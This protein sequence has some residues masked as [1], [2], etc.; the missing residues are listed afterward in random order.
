MSSP[1]NCLMVKNT[2]Q[3]STSLTSQGLPG[4]NVSTI[5][6][7]LILLQVWEQFLLNG[8]VAKPRH[9]MH[10]LKIEERGREWKTSLLNILSSP[11]RTS[12][13][14]L[15][16][17]PLVLS[18]MA[19]RRNYIFKCYI[20]FYQSSFTVNGNHLCLSYGCDAI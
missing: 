16:P 11:L 13:H 5:S 18:K 12:T 7:S 10:F 4:G 19:T 3:F 2:R 17:K 20:L 8:P 9:S 14:A 15:V 6:K 1:S